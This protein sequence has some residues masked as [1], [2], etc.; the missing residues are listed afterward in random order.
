LSSSTVSTIIISVGTSLIVSLITFIVGLRVGKNQADRAMLKDLY[1]QLIIHF[2]E[3]EKGLESGR[4]KKWSDYKTVGTQYVPLVREMRLNGLIVELTDKMATEIEEIESKCLIYGNN[5]H[6]IL[7]FIKDNFANLL[8]QNCKNIL[9][10]EEYQTRTDKDTIGKK[11]TEISYGCLLIKS[12]VNNIFNRLK[13][14]NQLG[15]SMQINIDGKNHSLYVYAGSLQDMDVADFILYF[16]N[17]IIVLPKLKDIIE[18]RENLLGKVIQTIAELK[19][20]ARD[21]HPFWRTLVTAFTDV[22]RK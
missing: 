8:K 14:D 7:P 16:H 2:Q 9:I 22:F 12:E 13:E 18:E 11:Y 4:P 17:E 21:P 5:H 1:R 10:E 6:L 19:K 3:I 15:I 20:H